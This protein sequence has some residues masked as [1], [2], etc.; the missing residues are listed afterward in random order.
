LERVIMDSWKFERRRRAFELKGLGWKQR[1]IAEAFGVSEASV[2][3]W[4]SGSSNPSDWGGKGRAGRRPRLSEA[5][6]QRLPTFLARGAPAYGFRGEVWTAA[7][8]AKVIRDEFGVSYEKSW[9]T[10]LLKR[11]H[12]TPQRPTPRASQR[13]EATIS[14]WREQRWP[15]IKKRPQPPG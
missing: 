9:V 4:L 11:V 10:Q 1:D 2:S 6:L 7:R 14:A 12:W 13:D 8:V 5:Q 15:E 3:R